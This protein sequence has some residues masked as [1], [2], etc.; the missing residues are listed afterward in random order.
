MK[1]LPLAFKVLGWLF[2]A[3]GSVALIYHLSKLNAQHPFDYELGWICL[4]R[5]LAVLG[6]VGLLRGHNWARWLLAV[7]MAYHI[8]LSLFHSPLELVLHGLLF[9]VIGYFLFRPQA[10]AHF[11]TRRSAPPKSPDTTSSSLAK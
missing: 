10:S 4:V 11:Q 9:G 8:V 1:K 6:G 7:W 5:V 3:V 2:I